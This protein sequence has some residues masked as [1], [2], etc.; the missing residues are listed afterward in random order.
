[1]PVP[2][3]PGFV[4]WAREQVV[5]WQKWGLR[6]A[7]CFPKVIWLLP[8]LSCASAA[9]HRDPNTVSALQ[10]GK[11]PLGGK[12]ISLQGAVSHLVQ[13]GHVSQLC[14]YPACLTGATEHHGHA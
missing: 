14:V 11:Q 5:T 3:H 12:L 6:M 10:E 9:R 8:L 4:Q 13:E 1:M 2:D 7:F